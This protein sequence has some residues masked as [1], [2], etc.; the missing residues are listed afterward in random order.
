MT[1]DKPRVR[2]SRAAF[3]VLAWA[4]VASV[5]VQV[6]LAGV[7]VM[8]DPAWWSWHRT[9]VHALGSSMRSSGCAHRSSRGSTR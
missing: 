7:A 8:S 4:L 1:D 9:F 2:Y 3:R 6:T 5:A